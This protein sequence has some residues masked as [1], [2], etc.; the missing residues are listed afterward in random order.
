MKVLTIRIF[1]FKSCVGEEGT[2]D[3]LRKAQHQ[4]IQQGLSD[5]ELIGLVYFEEFGTN[6]INQDI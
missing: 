6:S 3:A 1:S 4:I 5:K 2:K